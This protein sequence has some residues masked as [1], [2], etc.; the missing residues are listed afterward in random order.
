[1]QCQKNAASIRSKSNLGIARK[2]PLSQ[3]FFLRAR[4]KKHCEDGISWLIQERLFY[5]STIFFPKTF[6]FISVLRTTM[7][8]KMRG[9]VKRYKDAGW[10]SYIKKF[11]FFICILYILKV[12]QIAH[13]LKTIA[14]YSFLF[15]MWCFLKKESLSVSFFYKLV[16]V[17]WKLPFSHLG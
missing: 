11:N 9:Y 7:L 15:H 13:T 8:Y 16:R 3:C 5:R 17:K 2:T 10:N 14:F 4:M 1:M 6:F 12:Q